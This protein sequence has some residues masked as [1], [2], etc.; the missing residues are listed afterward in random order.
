VRE[1]P[2]KRHKTLSSPAPPDKRAIQI[3]RVSTVTATAIAVADMVG[4]GVFTSLDF[5]VR[6]ITSGFSLLMLWVVGGLTALCGAISYAELA[7]ALPRSGGEHNFFCRIYHPSLGFLAGRVSATVGFAAPTALAAMAFDVYF[8]GV[9]AGVPQLALGLGVFWIVALVHL[10]GIQH[11]STF[12]NVSTAIK[13][14]LIVAFI[15]AGFVSAFAS[16]RSLMPNPGRLLDKNVGSVDARD[17]ADRRARGAWHLF[18]YGRRR[19]ETQGSTGKLIL[20]VFGAVA[21]FERD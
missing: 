16:N 3:A 17:K 19:L 1:I 12:Q 18:P 4:I 6:E 9:V 20:H 11:G 7:T 10:I 13:V 15:V 2:H 21:Q 8:E 5:Q 14:V